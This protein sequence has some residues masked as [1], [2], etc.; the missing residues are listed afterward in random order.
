MNNPG[1]I[2]RGLRVTEKSTDMQANLNKYTFVVSPGYNRV[3]VADAVENLFDV[4][5]SH[6][7]I[8]TQP[9]KAKRSRTK[10]GVVGRKSG[11]RKAVVTLQEGSTIDLV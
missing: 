3:A 11:F 10:R 4:K 5:V 9:S 6:V 2:I 8:L 1:S 7:N